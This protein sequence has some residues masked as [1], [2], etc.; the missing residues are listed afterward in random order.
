MKVRLKVQMLDKRGL[1][2]LV[3]YEQYYYEDHEPTTVEYL[4]LECGART[5]RAC[6]VPNN[7]PL[8]CDKCITI[9]A[10]RANDRQRYVGRRA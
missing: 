8:T 9:E 5:I 2:H 3:A 10:R 7:T 1:I 6:E 4:Q